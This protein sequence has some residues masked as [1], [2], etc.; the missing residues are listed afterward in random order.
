MKND[1]KGK[2]FITTQDWSVEE[3]EEALELAADAPRI[4]RS[5]PT[6]GLAGSSTQLTSLPL[7]RSYQEFATM[8]CR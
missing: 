1:L 7:A 2:D 4:S 5:T 3:L 6:C 8:P